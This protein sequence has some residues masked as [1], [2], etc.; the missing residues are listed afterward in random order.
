MEI[1]EWEV[2]LRLIYMC[3]A[4]E[5]EVAVVYKEPL[6]RVSINFSLLFSSEKH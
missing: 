6:S 2:V 1:I 4:A 3:P 5:S